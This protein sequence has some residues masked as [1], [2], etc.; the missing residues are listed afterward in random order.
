MTHTD[1]VC[2]AAHRP[3]T[4]DLTDLLSCS[5]I[6]VNEEWTPHCCSLTIKKNVLVDNQQ[7]GFFLRALGVGLKP[8]GELVGDRG[9]PVT[10]VAEAQPATGAFNWV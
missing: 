2:L 7:V 10:P 6:L 5:D 9:Q 4:H 8:G 3:N 1:H